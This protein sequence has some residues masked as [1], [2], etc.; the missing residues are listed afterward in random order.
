MGRLRLEIIQNVNSFTEPTNTTQF[1][2]LGIIRCKWRINEGQRQVMDTFQI[3]QLNGGILVKVGI[4]REAVFD[5]GSFL[6]G[7]VEDG[8]VVAFGSCEIIFHF[9]GT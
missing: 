2:F 8:K 9:G 4:K 6:F 5:E 3:G 7:D 1:R